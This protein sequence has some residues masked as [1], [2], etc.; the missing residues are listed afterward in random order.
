MK[1]V[2]AIIRMNKINQTKKSLVEAGISS[3]HA[4]ECLGRG[5]GLVDLDLLK[6]AEQG[7][8]EA[9]AQLGNS[10][11]LIPKRMISII[12]PDKLINKTVSTIIAVNRTNKPGDGKIFVLPVFDVIRIRTGETGDETLDEG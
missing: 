3:M 5:K 10:Q 9:I 4:R 2:M 8:E 1:E 12:V 7:Y 11:R 6:G